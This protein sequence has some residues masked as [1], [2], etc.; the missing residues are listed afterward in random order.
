MLRAALEELRPKLQTLPGA[1]EGVDWEGKREE[2]RAYIDGRVRRV[3][4]N[5][6]GE[7][8]GAGG[9]RVGREEVEVIESV[10]AEGL[11]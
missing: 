10:L 8:G 2:R 11:R 6:G 7:R 9:P 5:M 4:G 3:V 1:V